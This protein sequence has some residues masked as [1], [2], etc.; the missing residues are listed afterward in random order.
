MAT[1]VADMSMSLDGFIADPDDSVGSLF[2]WYFNGDVAVPSRFPQRWTFHT[3]KASAEWLRES[4]DNAGAIVTGR[5]LFDYTDG[6]GGTH[7]WDVPVFVVT[8]EAPADWRRDGFTFVTDGIAAAVA[9][10]SAVAGDRWVGV[11]GPNVAQQCLDEGLLDLLRI[12]LV[13]VLFG[14]GIRF[15]DDLAGAPYRLEDPVVIEGRSVTH[16]QYR[17]KR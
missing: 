6:W 11:A 16:M 7:P 10:A 9:Q 13:P 5:R 2:D 3:S 12:N 14:E 8:H 17:V 1:V 15:F 4:M